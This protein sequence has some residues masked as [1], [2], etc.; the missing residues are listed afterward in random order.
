MSSLAIQIAVIFLISF[1]LPSWAGA[2]LITL[3]DAYDAALKSHE[4]VK[5]AEEN[6]I[7]AESRVDQAITYLYPRLTGSGAYT[8]YNEILPPGGRAGQIFQPQNEIRADLVLTQPI[9]TGGRTM[10]AWH[11]AQGMNQASKFD[12]SG[13]RQH[14]M[15]GVAEVYYAV[16]K[17]QKLVEVSKHSLERMEHHKKVTE[18][19][20]ATRKTKANIS[21][22]LRANTLVNQARIGV[23]RA[24]DGL[25]IA[26][27]KL[28]LVTGL[29]DTSEVV[30]PA[31]LAEPQDSIDTLIQKSYQQRDDYARSKLERKITEEFITI[32]R[33]G[34]APQVYAEGGL[35]YTLSDPDTMLDGTTYYAGIRLSIPLFEGGL[36]EAELAEAR[37]KQR[38]AELAS[39][40]LKRQIESDVREAYVNYQT[41]TSVLEN[42]KLQAADARTNFDTVEGLFAEGLVSSL[43]LI[44]A[45]QALFMAERELVSITLDRQVAI[46]R[47]EKSVGSLGKSN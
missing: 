19:E 38:Q 1:I 36:Q 44:D 46:I 2:S 18:R 42:A 3:Q 8:R 40:L 33:G 9:Y 29:P 39:K 11:A 15:A 34:H 21:S 45:E 47:L 41:V 24:Q 4:T 20:A 31:A 5:I 30:E 28:L 37:S 35:R 17:A 32:T 43:S 22:L 13:T 10:A 26:R 12:L 23:L 6:R 14:I 16:I 25:K 7:Q 27:Q